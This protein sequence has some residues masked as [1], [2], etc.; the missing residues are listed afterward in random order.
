MALNLNHQLCRAQTNGEKPIRFNTVRSL[1]FTTPQRATVSSRRLS[2]IC[3]VAKHII[4][5]VRWMLFAAP[6]RATTLTSAQEHSE[7]SVNWSSDLTHPFCPRHLSWSTWLFLGRVCQSLRVAFRILLCVVLR[8]RARNSSVS[9][10]CRLHH[11]TQQLQFLRVPADNY[12]S[13]Q[14]SSHKKRSAIE[15]NNNAVYSAAG[16]AC[17]RVSVACTVLVGGLGIDDGLG[18]L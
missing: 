8:S 1:L 11:N 7:G 15:L 13:R 5:T 2:S 12:A 4:K 14:L 9:C 18:P 17:P 16:E 10:T 6:A 3:S